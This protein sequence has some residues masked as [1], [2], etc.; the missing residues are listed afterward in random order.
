MEQKNNGYQ[1]TSKSS[2][3]TKQFKDGYQPTKSVQ[4]PPPKN[5]TPPPTKK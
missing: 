4:P 3:Q 1:P 2:S 5:P